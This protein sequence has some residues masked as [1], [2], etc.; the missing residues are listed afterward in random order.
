MLAQHAARMVNP[1]PVIPEA[2]AL[3]VIPASAQRVSGNPETR[4]VLGSGFPL[5]APLGGNDVYPSGMTA[6]AAS[7]NLQHHTPAYF[8]GEDVRRQR[9]D[10]RYRPRDRHGCQLRLVE[11]ARQPV[12]RFDAE[13]LWR[14]H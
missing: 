11:V 8:A 14:H 6:T 2:E 4:M 3:R 13:R 5:C 10:V 12:P 7:G 9:N 1:T